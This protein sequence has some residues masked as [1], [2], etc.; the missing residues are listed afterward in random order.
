[1]LVTL[2]WYIIPSALGNHHTNQTR[3]ND[4]HN[5]HRRGLPRQGH[6]PSRRSV[7]S[8]L[9]ASGKPGWARHSGCQGESSTRRASTRSV[10]TEVTSPDPTEGRASSRTERRAVSGGVRRCCRRIRAPASRSG[11]ACLSTGSPRTA[12][13]CMPLLMTAS[14]AAIDA[15]R[16]EIST[17][18]ERVHAHRARSTTGALTVAVGCPAVART[19]RGLSDAAPTSTSHRLSAS[20]ATNSTTARAS[21]VDPSGCQPHITSTAWSTATDSDVRCDGPGL[22]GPRSA[23]RRRGA[24]SPRKSASGG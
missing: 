9:G 3:R 23:R 2:R 5:R 12:R 18:P 17:E 14:R 21:Y 1:M 8:Q 20:E 6:T 11:C 13:H 15:G 10:Q 24:S 7:R 4:R 16:P 19:A 22:A